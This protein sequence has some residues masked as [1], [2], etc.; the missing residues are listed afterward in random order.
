MIS[1]E[2]GLLLQCSRPYRASRWGQDA[3]K[4]RVAGQASLTVPYER[5]CPPRVGYVNASIGNIIVLP[6]Y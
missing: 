5:V 2:R 1:L 4:E 6:G 3:V